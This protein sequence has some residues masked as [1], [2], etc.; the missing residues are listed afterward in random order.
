M[1]F[2]LG[3]QIMVLY[4]TGTL[5]IGLTLEHKVEVLHYI[6]NHQ[7]LIKLISPSL[8]GSQYVHLLFG[9]VMEC[10]GWLEWRW[11]VGIPYRGAQH[12]AWNNPQLHLHA[13]TRSRTWWQGCGS[14][15]EMDSR[16]RWCNLFTILGE[17]LSLGEFISWWSSVGLEERFSIAIGLI[18]FCLF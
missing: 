5:N 13:Y 16:S 18:G 2:Q 6:N 10:V 7:V 17:V 11:W 4:F 14:R 3:M 1:L 8:I 12:N 15:K 9:I